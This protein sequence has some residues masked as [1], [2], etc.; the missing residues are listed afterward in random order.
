M[1]FTFTIIHIFIYLQV[2][3]VTKVT[4]LIRYLIYLAF[5]FNSTLKGEFAVVP[6]DK[7]EGG[8]YHQKFLLIW[9]AYLWNYVT[10]PT[11]PKGHIPQKF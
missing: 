2:S 3:N 4:M 11:W 1:H 7:I 8:A 10:W 9:T 6:T 5:M